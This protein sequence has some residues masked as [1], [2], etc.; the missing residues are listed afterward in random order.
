MFSAFTT[1]AN[2][3]FNGIMSDNSRRSTPRRPP[4]TPAPVSPVVPTP[5]N[6]S[7]STA[8]VPSPLRTLTLQPVPWRFN[9]SLIPIN[10][11]LPQPFTT[12]LRPRNALLASLED[13]IDPRHNSQAQQHGLNN[14]QI[15]ITPLL[16]LGFGVPHNAGFLNIDVGGYSTIASVFRQDN[17]NA[18]M[19]VDGML[20]SLQALQHNISLP[21][22]STNLALLGNVDR[23]EPALIGFQSTT[24]VPDVVIEEL[25]D[26]L[27]ANEPMLAAPQQ[28][29]LATVATAEILVTPTIVVPEARPQDEPAL[30]QTT[31]LAPPTTVVEERAPLQ[32]HINTSPSYEDALFCL[33]Q[34]ILKI[35]KTSIKKDTINIRNKMMALHQQK[36]DP[37]KLAHCLDLTNRLLTSPPG[38]ERIHIAKEYKQVATTFRNMSSL[39]WKALGIAMCALGATVLSVGGLS[40]LSIGS[41]GPGIS[42]AAAGAGL[43]GFGLF[44]L[45]RHES[46]EKKM[47]SLQ[48]AIIAEPGA[49]L[50]N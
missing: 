27:P 46:A 35:Q 41:A 24:T 43:I 32:A 33:N 14:G 21:T 12:H 13:I 39:L 7:P 48:T 9:G 11:T 18:V 20:F 10:H 50:S 3:V 15:R 42:I 6:A 38:Q 4:I 19:H 37:T 40:L 36:E 30:H 28:L 34:N 49:I 45:K 8:I 25:P 47:N 44:T 31:N 1:A 17:G 22:N 23:I 16:G 5:F 29:G 2:F 26:G